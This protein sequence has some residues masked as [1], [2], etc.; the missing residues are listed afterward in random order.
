MHLLQQIQPQELANVN[1]LNTSF[2]SATY[3]G[4]ILN[5]GTDWTTGW[6]SYPTN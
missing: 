4:A 2:D 6:T 5:G 1:T 3:Y